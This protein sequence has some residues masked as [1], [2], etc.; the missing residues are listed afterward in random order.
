LMSDPAEKK[1]RIILGCRQLALRSVRIE[2]TDGV[3]TDRGSSIYRLTREGAVFITNGTVNGD[4]LYFS[5]VGE[6]TDV[7]LLTSYVVRDVAES[8]VD[9]YSGTDISGTEATFTIASQTFTKDQQAEHI[10]DYASSIEKK[11]VGIIWPPYTTASPDGTSELVEGYFICAALAGSISALP[12]Q[13]GFTNLKLSGFD[14]LSFSN[15]GYFKDSQLDTMASGGVMIFTQT[16]TDALIQ[17][18][19]QLMTNMSA[20]EYRELSIVKNVDYIAKLL[21]ARIRPFIGIWNITSF[22]LETLKV[23]L[24][25]TFADLKVSDDIAG[26]NIT[27]AQIVSLEENA[28][29]PDR[30][31][32]IVDL[33]IPYPANDIRVTLRI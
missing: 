16:S 19:H 9:V 12:A 15:L 22:F 33:G 27:S 31:D 2:S 30:I 1:E 7:A 11:R 26:P 3:I 14:R 29:S 4:R 18:R 10:R 23:L 28:T 20:I 21:R 13:Q 6:T 25:G 17:C 8:Y 24:Q 5:S 32:V